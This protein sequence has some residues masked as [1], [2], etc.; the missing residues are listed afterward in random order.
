MASGLV[1]R[2][3]RVRVTVDHAAALAV[4]VWLAVALGAVV[5]AR[6]DFTADG[7]AA[8]YAY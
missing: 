2:L 8:V 6:D 1:T 7:A 4:G 5:F 3:G